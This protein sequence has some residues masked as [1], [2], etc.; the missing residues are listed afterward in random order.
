MLKQVL[1]G[2]D[3]LQSAG[4]KLLIRLIP[5]LHCRLSPLPLPFI[6]PQ[7]AHWSVARRC[8][9]VRAHHHPHP[10]PF[11]LV[12]WLIWSRLIRSR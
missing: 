7:I 4:D 9:H 11:N 8:K 6:P 12:P 5:P 10:T 2:V 1:L 3:V